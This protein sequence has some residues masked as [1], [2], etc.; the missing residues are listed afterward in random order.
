MS[1][2]TNCAEFGSRVLSSRPSRLGWTCR[3]RECLHCGSRFTTYEV[4]KENLT[5]A[6]GEDGQESEPE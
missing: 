6:S 5:I 1:A 4:P 3:R 2:C